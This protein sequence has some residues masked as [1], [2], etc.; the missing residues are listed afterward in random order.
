M[1]IFG[2]KLID[3]HTAEWQFEHFEVLI[4]YLGRDLNMPD[5]VLHLPTRENFSDPDNPD[6]KH[7]GHQLAEFL[8][9]KVKRQCGVGDI[10]IKLIPTQESKPE[11][12]GGSVILQPVGKNAAVGRYIIRQNKH[13]ETVEKIT[14]DRD[15]TGDPSQLVAT[16]AHELS[17]GLHNRMH[18]I[19]E[20]EEEILYE[21][22]TDLTAIY[23]GYGVFI[24]NGK[25]KFTTDSDSWSSQS[26]GY[27][28]E[29]EIIFATA[30]FMK[31]KGVSLNI[32]KP[33]LKPHL[34]KMLGKAFKQ[35]EKYKSEI[36]YLQGLRRPKTD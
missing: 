33:F 30:L 25:S 11:K 7:T 10:Q 26:I 13:G 4:K 15:L 19:P 14:Y 23:L 34:F 27:L 12:L 24:A 21:M 36:E 22:F 29:S 9:Q 31:L 20:F 35:L 6:A 17:H 2:G 16:F 5:F 8:L 18:N 3:R 28:S 32:P 1:G